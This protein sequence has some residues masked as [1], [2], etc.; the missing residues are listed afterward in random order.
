MIEGIAQTLN[1]QR[2]QLVLQPLKLHQSG[3]LSLANQDQLDGIILLNTH[4]EDEDLQEVINAHFPYDSFF[5]SLLK[6]LFICYYNAIKGTV[7]ILFIVHGLIIFL[8]RKKS[9]PL[10][11][12]RNYILTVE[13]SERKVS[14][15]I[16]RPKCQL[17][18][19]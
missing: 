12:I 4:D 16:S 17:C 7:S 18:F 11:S 9:S 14:V 15:S 2:C 8:K 1:K 3:Y 6:D 10:S 13:K 19:F 5:L